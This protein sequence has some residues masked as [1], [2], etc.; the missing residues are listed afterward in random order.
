LVLGLG[1]ERGKERS[2]VRD[3]SNCTVPKRGGKKV[4]RVNECIEKKK[5]KREKN[6]YFFSA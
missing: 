1:K 2:R 4:K 3:C 5:R 6:N